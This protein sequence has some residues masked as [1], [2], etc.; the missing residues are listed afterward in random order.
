MPFELGGFSPDILALL[1]GVAVL[2]GILD[3]LAGGGGLL[4]LPALL[5]SGVPPL[6]ALG[7]NKLQG[8]SG[9]AMSTFM[10]LRLR[11]V[12]LAEVKGLMLSAFIGSAAGTVLVQNID[13]SALNRI[14]PFVLLF[15]AVYFLFSPR[16]T[17]GDQ[18]ARLSDRQYRCGVVPFIGAYDGMFGPG[19]GSFF[20]LSGVAWRGLDLIRA[21]AV[22]KTLN[23]SANFAS[24][25]VFLLAFKVVWAAGILMMLGQ[26][27]GAW[28]GSHTLL[29][30]DPRL[31]RVVIVIMSVA[32]LLQYLRQHGLG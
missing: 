9:T 22:A 26:V 29:R 17:R 21:T 15:I 4:T 6:F 14:I 18:K 24:L 10:M 5:L 13:T 11:Q 27:V 28:A 19:T 12:N 8:S 25:L 23:F 16:I 32:M 1:F 30:I 20:A 7:T 3:T 2:A 31:L